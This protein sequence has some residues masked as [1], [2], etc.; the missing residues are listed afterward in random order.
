MNDPVMSQS[1][2][3]PSICLDENTCVPAGIRTKD[4][5]NTRVERYRYTRL[6]VSSESW[7]IRRRYSSILLEELR[8]TT[9]VFTWIFVNLYE[10][11]TQ[12]LPNTGLEPLRLGTQ[13]VFGLI[14]FRSDII[15]ALA[16][17][18]L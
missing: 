6:L 15:N 8:D 1:G 4:V 10:I 14:S 9:K 17:K 18:H 16:L 5:P 2:Y 12:Y 7:P 13:S 3:Y 11:R